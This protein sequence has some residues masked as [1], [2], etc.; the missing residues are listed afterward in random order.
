[1]FKKS[2]L[3]PPRE[4]SPFCLNVQKKISRASERVSAAQAGKPE[5]PPKAEEEAKL[6]EQVAKLHEALVQTRHVD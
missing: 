4:N 1:M 6:P 5:S 2:L 3:F